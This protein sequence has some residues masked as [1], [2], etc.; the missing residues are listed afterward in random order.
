[1][2][3]TFNQL[4]SAL[5]RQKPQIICLSGDEPVLLQS[6]VQ[7]IQAYAKD[8]GFSLNQYHDLEADFSWQQ[9][10]SLLQQQDLFNS[11]SLL[12]ILNAATKFDKATGVIIKQCCKQLPANKLIL[13]R[14]GKLSASQAKSAWHQAIKQRGLTLRI[15]PLNPAQSSAWIAKFTTQQNLSP[16]IMRYI[17]QITQ[18]NLTDIQQLIEK[19]RLAP[20]DCVIDERYIQQQLTS[21]LE[22]NVFAITDAILHADL[23]AVLNYTQ[24]ISVQDSKQL[25]LLA[26]ALGQMIERILQQQQ[27]KL[28]YIAHRN[29]QQGIQRAAQ[30]LARPQLHA[31]LQKLSTVDKNLKG[32]RS[33]LLAHMSIQQ[34]YDALFA[35]MLQLT[36]ACHLQAGI[37]HETG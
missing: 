18:N 26:W 8:S 30:R 5:S 4:N 33:E 20:R 35:S 23:S 25:I 6:A 32:C 10:P 11:G 1:M 14:S 24:H 16:Q 19:I 12:H 13:I 7:Q 27:G 21:N 2:D 28:G 22:L 9:L 29:T 37:T 15:W 17:V 34:C 31:V 36:G 3:I